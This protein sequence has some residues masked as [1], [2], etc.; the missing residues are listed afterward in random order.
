MNRIADLKSRGNLK[1]RAQKFD[2]AS[3]LYLETILE[4]EDMDRSHLNTKEKNEMKTLEV[5]SR[6]NYCTSK[7]KIHDW[8]VILHQTRE[9]LKIEPENCKAKFKLGQA[10]Y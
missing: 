3:Q 6:L 2:E 10:L 1:F 5:S 9:V 7:S 8:E 4:I